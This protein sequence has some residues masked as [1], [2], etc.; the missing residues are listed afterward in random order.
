MDARSSYLET[1][2]RG[3]T[4]VQLVI[5]LY[6]QAIA[7]LRQAIVALAKGD[8]ETRTREINH[9]LLLIGQLHGSLD[10][11]RGGQVAGNLERFYNMMR[12]SLAEAQ[13]KQS[14]S[15][16]EEQIS[17][18]VLVHGAWLEVDRATNVREA[19]VRGPRSPES[20]RPVSGDSPTVATSMDWN[21]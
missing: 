11:D 16:L 9:A 19:A 17:H 18:L 8:V 14:A 12:A 1:A 13:V 15:I 6:E 5:L 10:L 20:R 3:A 4:Q 7:D 2:V 21:A